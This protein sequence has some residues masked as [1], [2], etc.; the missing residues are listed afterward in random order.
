MPGEGEHNRNSLGSGE[1][2]TERAES[3]QSFNLGITKVDCRTT[4]GGVRTGFKTKGPPKS[5]LR[6][7]SSHVPSLPPEATPAP[8]QPHRVAAGPHGDI[9]SRPVHV[10]TSAHALSAWGHL[11]TP[12]PHGDI[13]S[14][15]S[16]PA[17]GHPPTPCLCGDICSRPAHM[18]TT[19]HALPCPLGDIAHALSA[20]GHPLTPS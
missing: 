19:A 1:R 2:E 7:E 13:C 5:L 3:E 15:P 8:C 11:L 16:L 20:W 10:G 4:K 9:C 12:C 6:A 18:G 14:C 17:W